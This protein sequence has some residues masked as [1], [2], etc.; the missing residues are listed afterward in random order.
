MLEAGTH[1]L[2]VSELLCHADISTTA[3]VYAHLSDEVARAAMDGL[4]AT[5]EI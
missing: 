5:Y 3:E 4:A 1:L 2:V